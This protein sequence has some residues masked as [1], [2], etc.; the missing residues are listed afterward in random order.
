M[1]V[2]EWEPAEGEHCADPYNQLGVVS[3]PTKGEEGASRSSEGFHY[4]GA[5]PSAD[6]QMES[7]EEVLGSFLVQPWSVPSKEY[8]PKWRTAVVLA[9]Q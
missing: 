6:R 9:G 4:E 7:T 8:R 2:G 3:V 1:F 5:V